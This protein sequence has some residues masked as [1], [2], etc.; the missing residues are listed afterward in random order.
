MKPVALSCLFLLI[1]GAIV[2]SCA[3]PLKIGQRA[4]E[5]RS[6]GDIAKDNEI[7]VDVNTVMAK[8]ETAS[9]STEIYEQRL[10]VYG[11]LDEKATFD[12]FRKDT[13]AVE[14]IKQLHWH[15]LFMTEE[16]QKAK[17]DEMLGFSGGLKVKAA[18]EKVW[19]ETEGINSLNYR[20]AVGALGDAYVLGRAFTAAER[21]QAL[22][23]VRGVEGV[24]NVVDYVE[25]RPK[26]D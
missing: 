21:D 11:L 4:L 23:A 26:E 3:S 9:V 20:V 8:Y 17:E 2:S 19:L 5:E 24:R 6:F 22:A 10:V 13:Q 7:V 25:V 18:V 1:A 12:D 15:V 16:E 14:D